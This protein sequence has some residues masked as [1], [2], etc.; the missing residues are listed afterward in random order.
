MQSGSMQRVEFNSTSRGWRV[1][2]LRAALAWNAAPLARAVAWIT[3]A[4]QRRA[5]H[6]AA[7]AEARRLEWWRSH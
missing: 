6:A 7:E 1:L 2:T 4:R 5:A 3:T